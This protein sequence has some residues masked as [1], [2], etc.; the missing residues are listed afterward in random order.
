MEKWKIGKMGK[1]KSG[2]RGLGLGYSLMYFFFV[3]PAKGEKESRI[4]K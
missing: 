2:S 4:Y 3:I 1:W